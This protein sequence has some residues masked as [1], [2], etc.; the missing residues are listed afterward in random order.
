[1][2][3]I[4]IVED[5]FAIALDLQDRLES[6]GYEVLE[7]CHNYKD[8]LSALVEHD[9]DLILMD[10]NLN[11]TKN[12]IETALLIKE[13]FN[14]P[15][16]FC[17]ALTDKETFD[18]AMKASPYG[19]I[20]KPFKNDELRNNIELTLHKIK[21]SQANSGD[22][23]EANKTPDSIF[24]KSKN[25]LIRLQFNEILF[26]EAMDNY[27]NVYSK[28]GKRYTVSSYL[29]DFLD[30]LPNSQ[31]MRIH[32]SYIVAL[33]AIKAIESNSLIL[34]NDHQITIGRSYLKDVLN[35]INKVG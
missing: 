31:F 14:K 34:K 1:M 32:R 8:A 33:D 24:V 10:I 28:D 11:D 25:Q 16:I 15:I 29:S 9:T 22:E 3:K 26:A 5:E 13:K 27:T 4:L 20:N 12:G 21:A 23:S 2:S 6:M 30:H 35:S 17:T 19:F 7:I 18:A